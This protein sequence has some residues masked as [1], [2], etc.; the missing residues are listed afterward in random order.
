MSSKKISSNWREFEFMFHQ[1]QY[2][3]NPR[4]SLNQTMSN[5]QEI[6]EGLAENNRKRKP[7]MTAF[8]P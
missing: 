4:I 3:I 1:V 6:R 2:A 7:Q 5:W 8:N